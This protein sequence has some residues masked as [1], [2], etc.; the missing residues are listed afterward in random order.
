MSKIEHVWSAVK[1]PKPDVY[2][3]RRDGSTYLTRRY[4]DGERWYEVAFSDS[5]GGTPFTWPKKSGVK[6]PRLN[7]GWGEDLDTKFFLR[8]IS[9]A[10]LAKHVIEWSTPRKFFEPDEVLAHLVKTG[11]L[12]RDW[13]TAYQDEMRRFA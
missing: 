2:W 8:R 6:K 3:T 1:P 4:W 7:C 11:V 5:R 9:D 10:Q 12:P 13:K